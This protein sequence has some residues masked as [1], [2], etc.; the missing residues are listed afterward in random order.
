MAI[1]LTGWPS[2][3]S[4]GSENSIT[5]GRIHFIFY[6]LE[7]LVSTPRSE[8]MDCSGSLAHEISYDCHLLRTGHPVNW[9]AIQFWKFWLWIVE[10]KQLFLYYYFFPD[11]KKFIK[12]F[13]E[14]NFGKIQI[15]DLWS[16]L[17]RRGCT[18]P[19]KWIDKLWAPSSLLPT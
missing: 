5:S 18:N 19:F 7:V 1:Q 16:Q 11:L 13:R 17:F 6:S 10:T 15:F 8:S 9:M 12:K 4:I 2:S 3:F 14:K